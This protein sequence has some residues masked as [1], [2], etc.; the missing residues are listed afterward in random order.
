MDHYES[1]EESFSDELSPTD[2]YFQP[3]DSSQNIPV[4]EDRSSS[5]KTT[6]AAEER[7]Q[8]VSTPLSQRRRIGGLQDFSETSPLLDAE[9][10]PPAYTVAIAA[11]ARAS[12]SPGDE[13][14]EAA[15]GTNYGTT[16][17]PFAI[18]REPQSMAALADK[19]EAFRFRESIFRDDFIAGRHS[20]NIRVVPGPSDQRN[21]VEVRLSFSTSDNYGVK[22]IRY[23]VTD[24]SLSLETPIFKKLWSSFLGEAC[25]DVSVMISIAPGVELENFEINSYNSHLHLMSGIDAA[26][27]NTTDITLTRGS[28]LSDHFDSRRT[29]I[30]VG[31]GSVTGVYA[32]RDLLSITTGSG[33][34]EVSVDPK[35][36]SETYPAPAESV[37][38]SRDGAIAVGFPT[39]NSLPFAEH[40]ALGLW[41][42]GEIPDRDFRTT[43][44]ASSGSVKGSF[45]H[46]SST[47]LRSSSGSIEASVH[48]LHAGSDM[49]T[50]ETESDSGHIALHV[51]E[52]FFEPNVPMRHLSSSH[53]TRSG[54]IKL[55]YP[56]A[57]EGKIHGA[58]RS[59][60]LSLEGKDV[61]I[62]ELEDG[63][64]LARK[65]YGQSELSFQSRSGSVH[66]RV[67]DR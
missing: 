53:C 2:G 46:G 56:H 25:V 40:K 10:P 65:G 27:L 52:P 64:V 6:E 61:E 51:S 66:V 49:T 13:D 26:I 58:S 55:Q 17:T 67:G 31:S 12:S 36:G 54:S 29:I 50:I 19:P 15:S 35:N 45:L 32:L 9:P 7:R 22:Q 34:I 20:G 60:K 11:G 30:N 41:N 18:R 23:A 62:V 28:L 47:K 3:R 33:K 14:A 38:Q 8:F 43:V 37:F 21:N 16:F 44:S 57:W 24:S 59:G 42:S 63:K 5:A 1:D 4:G 48:P 39:S